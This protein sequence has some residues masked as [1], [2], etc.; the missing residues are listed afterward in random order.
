MYKYTLSTSHKWGKC[1]IVEREFLFLV[2]RRPYQSV[3]TDSTS[4]VSFKSVSVMD[5]IQRWKRMIISRIQKRAVTWEFQSYDI[6]H[7]VNSFPKRLICS[8]HDIKTVTMN[9]F[10]LPSIMIQTW[11]V[12]SSCLNSLQKSGS[13]VSHLVSSS[14]TWHLLHGVSNIPRQKFPPYFYYDEEENHLKSVFR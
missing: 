6:V 10:F 1:V 12:I 13:R 9:S 11:L 14:I 2:Y 7:H 4:A 3:T 8:S 5:L